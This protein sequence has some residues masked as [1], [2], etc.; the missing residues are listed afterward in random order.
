MARQLGAVPRYES[1]HKSERTKRALTQRAESRAPH[2]KRAF[3]W[4]RVYDEHG[5]PRQVIEPTEADA[6]SDAAKRLLAGQSLR[7]IAAHLEDSGIRA[8][9]AKHWTASAVRNVL[10]RESNVSRLVRYGEVVGQGH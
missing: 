8:P 6:L 7:S 4:A 3:G 5:R 10:L 9:G 2:G 1:E